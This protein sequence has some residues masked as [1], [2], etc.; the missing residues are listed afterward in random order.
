[1]PAN[2]VDYLLN[3]HIKRPLSI[4]RAAKLNDAFTTET[5]DICLVKYLYDKTVRSDQEVAQMLDAV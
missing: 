4:K 1:M 2:A 3:N 5:I